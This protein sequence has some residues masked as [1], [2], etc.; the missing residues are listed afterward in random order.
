MRAYITKIK[1]TTEYI[2]Y[3][4]DSLRYFISNESTVELIQAIMKPM[5]FDELTEQGFTFTR[6]DYDYFNSVLSEKALTKFDKIPNNALS[7]LVI[8]ISN[9]CNLGCKYCYANEG[10]YHSSEELMSCEVAIKVMESFYSVFDHIE[11]VQLFGGEPCL[12][13][14]VVECICKY[15]SSSNKNTAIGLVTNGTIMPDN[16]ME[17][18]KNHNIYTT[19]SIDHEQIHDMV[20]PYKNGK[21]SFEK[22]VSNMMK[23][24]ALTGKPNQIELTYTSLHEK[25]GITVDDA[26]KSVEYIFGQ[27]PVHLVPVISD[28]PMYRL[29][30][31]DSFIDSI[32]KY[33]ELKRKNTTRLQH[34]YIQRFL[35]PLMNRTPSSMYCSAGQGTLSVSTNGDVYSCFYFTDDEEQKIT[36]IFK[37]SNE[38][39]NDVINARNYYHSCSSSYIKDCEECFA[40]TICYNCLGINFSETGDLYKNPEFQCDLTRK[41]LQ[42]VLEEIGDDFC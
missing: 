11:L 6:E 28:E 1:E 33:F 30:N 37:S 7:R 40:N 3:L 18:I 22:I 34:T 39:Y 14:P 36:N 2:V 35:Y 4:P 19:L 41:G 17:L 42:R 26:I 32:S 9:A 31:T 27:I 21:G 24:R 20:R 12:N 8:N 16:L 29:S 25:I 13:I 15:I 5:S 10:Q 38:F 23:L